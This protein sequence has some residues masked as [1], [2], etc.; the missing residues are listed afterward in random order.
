MIWIIDYPWRTKLNVFLWLFLSTRR[1]ST[2]IDLWPWP[3]LRIDP[4]GVLTASS[5]RIQSVRCVYI[6][7][8]S[9]CSFML[10]KLTETFSLLTCFFLC[11]FFEK[12]SW[13]NSTQVPST[14]LRQV[15]ELLILTWMSASTF[16]FV[17]GPFKLIII[18]CCFILPRRPGSI[19]CHQ[20]TTQAIAAGSQA[21]QYWR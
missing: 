18:F 19:Q 16:L 9:V 15:Y 2:Q 1:W 7:L 20:R 21:Y 14:Y 6:F 11:R 17:I 5:W 10:E 4:N 8:N 13:R 12:M 3:Q